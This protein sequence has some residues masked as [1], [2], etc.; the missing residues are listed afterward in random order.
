VLDLG[1]PLIATTI[2][3]NIVLIYL[4]YLSTIKKKYTLTV[5]LVV[6]IFIFIVTPA[7]WIFNA[8]TLGG[9]PYYIITFSSLIAILIQGSKKYIAL[10][11][12]II[13][14]SILTLLEYKYPDLIQNFN[15]PIVRFIDIYIGLIINSVSNAF[16]FS[17]ILDQYN[18]EQ[19]KM[20]ECLVQIQKQELE[21]QYQDNL[22]TVNQQLQ[23]EIDE[24]KRM[25]REIFLLDRLHLVGEMAAGLGHEIRN[26]MTT[27]RGFLQVLRKSDSKKQEYFD[28]MIEELDR[29]N[30]IITEFL[31]LAKNKRVE[32]KRQDLNKII[33]TV[34]PLIKADS[35]KANKYIHFSGGDIPE[36]LLDE[37]EIRQLILNLIRNGLEAMSAGGNLTMSTFVEG[38]D[39]VLSVQDEGQG[40][41]PDVLEKMGTPFFTTKDNG[42]GLG[43]AV[44]Y[45]IVAR[46]NACIKIETGSMG[47]KFLVRF[48][49]TTEAVSC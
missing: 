13:V 14:A 5:V 15:T 24:R 23:H 29:A 11:L 10:L 18:Q 7:S 3:A 41:D 37:G 21:I 39:I 49:L 35:F 45:S 43:L 28:L 30:L 1:A 36:I 26:P 20:R 19:V 27:V 38:Q 42:T 6:S 16:L 4:Y 33:K 17:F 22:R 34:L 12:L 25:E 46:H 48:K 2:S 44:C 47:T 40:I 31:F 8:G 9:I 32:F